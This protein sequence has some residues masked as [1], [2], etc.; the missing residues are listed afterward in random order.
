MGNCHPVLIRTSALLAKCVL[1]D[2][3]MGAYIK[4]RWKV[5]NELNVLIAGLGG[6]GVVSTA[7]ILAEAAFADGRKASTADF[8]GATQRFGST[9]SYVRIGEEIY[10][11]NFPAGEADLLLGFEPLQCLKAGLTYA[12]EDGL[13]LMSDRPIGMQASLTSQYPTIDEITGDLKKMGIKRIIHFDA[14]DIAIRETGNIVSLNMVMLGAALA[15]GIVPVQ[16]GTLETTI[17]KLSPRGT[18]KG[19]LK[20]FKAGMKKFTELKWTSTPKERGMENS[21]GPFFSK[22]GGVLNFVRRGKKE[23]NLPWPF[24]VE[25]INI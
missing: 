25:P 9:Y 23:S 7:R 20:A 5:S 11:T 17:T 4:R 1:K 12:S 21:A 24:N 2:A 3:H 13:I 22:I 15:S 16:V 8:V 14:G 18:A 10:S 19:N 6:Q